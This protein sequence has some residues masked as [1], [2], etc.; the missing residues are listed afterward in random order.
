M[1][2][3]GWVEAAE[4][5]LPYVVKLEMP[6]SAG[7]GFF[8]AYRTEKKQKYAVIATAAHVI[9]HASEWSEPIRIKAC[10]SAAMLR[11]EQYQI[12]TCDNQDLAIIEVPWDY[13]D[14]PAQP[15][16]MANP[17]DSLPTG[18]PIAWCGFPNIAEGIICLFTGHI[19]AN[20]EARGNY[21]IDGVVIH[22]V[23]GGPAFVYD[24]QGITII[25]LLSQYL[26][27]RA[28][29]ESLPGLGVVRRINPMTDYLNNHA[30]TGKQK[31][32]RK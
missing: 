20:V 27:N 30:K 23:S 9:Q 28:T 14:L 18:H 3:N 12:L 17:K 31:A 15:L 2:T 21:L 29:G 8:I 7:S 1:K 10:K 5:M 25:G 32:G 16:P 19:S 22:G 4:I 24:G 26:P 6:D 11:P 13:V